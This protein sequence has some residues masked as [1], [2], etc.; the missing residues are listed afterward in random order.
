MDAIVVVP[1]DID[2]DALVFVSAFVVSGERAVA[3]E[4]T[5]GEKNICPPPQQGGGVPEQYDRLIKG[6]RL[7]HAR[8]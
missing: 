5:Y 7:F 2:V 4:N 8:L 3:S 6:S 1:V